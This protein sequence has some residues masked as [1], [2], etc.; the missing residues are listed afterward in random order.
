MEVVHNKN[1]IHRDIKPDNF[2]MEHDNLPVIKLIDF[3]LA[4]KY[5]NPVTKAHIEFK[6]NQNFVGTVRYV[7]LN[8]HKGY[9]ESRRDDLEAICYVMLY[10]IKGMLP[11]E[12]MLADT[13]EEKYKLIGK[14][15]EMKTPDFMF[16]KLPS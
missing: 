13:K 10:L 14:Y 12:G 7:S 1:Y 8:V 9:M 6:E 5:R 4:K 16:K 11:W 2:L 15:K 3:G